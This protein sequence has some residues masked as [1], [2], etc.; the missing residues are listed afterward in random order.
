MDNFG[1]A[2]RKPQNLFLGVCK[3][4]NNTRLK[5]LADQSNPIQMENSQK[6]IV[7]L[8]PSTPTSGKK[9][10]NKTNQ[11]GIILI[12]GNI[13]YCPGW[14]V[15][16]T[17]ELPFARRF[18][19]SFVCDSTERIRDSRCS[20]PCG[21]AVRDYGRRLPGPPCPS[22]PQGLISSQALSP[23]GPQGSQA[24]G[25]DF[26]SVGYRNTELQRGPGMKKRLQF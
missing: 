4:N 17:A 13:F 10:N 21:D 6:N 26:W 24:L 2:T 20:S 1:Q 12:H 11:Q 25:K 19:P 14:A 9:K 23:P 7:S 5:L 8:I 16:P 15:P 22:S 3:N 18:S